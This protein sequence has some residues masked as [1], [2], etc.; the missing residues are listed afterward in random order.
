MH[1]ASEGSFCQPRHRHGHEVTLK[2]ERTMEG[3]LIVFG[4][5]LFVSQCIRL[6]AAIDCF[7]ELDC[8]LSSH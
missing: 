5:P 6:L 2:D 3:R 1:H 4:V 7:S 8:D